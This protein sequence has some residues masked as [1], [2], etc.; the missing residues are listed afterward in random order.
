MLEEL[1]RALA[2]SP[3]A[4]LVL[5]WEQLLGGP[6]TTLLQ[7]YHEYGPLA[8]QACDVLSTMHSQTMADLKVMKEEQSFFLFFYCVNARL[9][10]MFVFSFH[11][12]CWRC[13]C[14]WN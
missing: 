10:V 12:A 4:E 7:N 13:P 14:L 8:S 3:S 6:L 1:C 9:T 2:S 5:F 11:S